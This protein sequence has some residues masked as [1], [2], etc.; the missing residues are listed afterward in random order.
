MQLLFI[1]DQQADWRQALLSLSSET[2]PHSSPPP[3]SPET[4]NLAEALVRLRQSDHPQPRIIC[5]FQDREGIWQAVE[6]HINIR[7]DQVSAHPV[8]IITPVERNGQ[9]ATP[10]QTASHRAQPAIAQT[11]KPPFGVINSEDTATQVG[12]TPA[13][14][15]WQAAE[16]YRQA[17][18]AA[19][20]GL[21]VIDQHNLT[22]L[23]NERMAALLGYCAEE[24]VGKPFLDF[25]DE[26]GKS[27]ALMHLE[28]QR[29]GISEQFDFR[30]LR[31]DGS[32]DYVRVSASPLRDGEGHYAGTL[33]VITDVLQQRRMAAA[34]REWEDILAGIL[35]SAMDAI[36]SIDEDFQVFLFNSAAE[37]MFACNRHEALGQ[38]LTRFL[39]ERFRAEHEAYLRSFADSGRSSETPAKRRAIFGLRSDGEEFPIE[40]SVSKMEVGG[41]KIL[42]IILRDISERV[43]T[44]NALKESEEKFRLLV[45]G[46]QD[47]A[48][49]RLDAEGHIASWNAGAERIMGYKAAEI[50]GKPCTIFYT[51]TDIENFIPE[52]ELAMAKKHGRYEDE[53]WR[54]R[55]D[56]SLFLANFVLT[57]L[58]DDE[59]GLRGFVNVTRDVTQRK[60]AE[61]ALREGESRLR[62]LV[63]SNVIGVMVAT[64]K[65]QVT[66]ANDGFLKMIGYSRDQLDAGEIAG[67]AMT[68]PEYQQ[69]DR[70]A[71]AQLKTLGSC[72]PFEK[73]LI[74]QDRARVSVLIAGT[75]LEGTLDSYI[76]FVLDLTERKQV[77]MLRQRFSHR[78][79]EAQENERRGLA[80]ELHDEIGQ[81][82]T[83]VMINLQA[84]KLPFEEGTQRVKIEDCL[85]LV[86]N[87]LQ[88]VR[89]MS[90]DLR[91]SIL[92]DLGLAAALRWYVK[93]QTQRA[94]IRAR[95]YTNMSEE[96]LPVPIETACFRI[97]QEAITNVLKHAQ[98]TNIF[99]E[100][101]QDAEQVSLTIH[102]NG[103][104]FDVE[105][106]YSQARH[107]GSVGLLGMQERAQFVNGQV[108]VV[109]S[110]RYGTMVRARLPHACPSPTYSHVEV[111]EP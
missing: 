10:D 88:Q 70:E 40:A 111:Y 100:V 105:Q 30:F 63:E 68:P 31:K 101:N 92:D 98:A 42:T 39:P 87:V 85:H 25:L 2:P 43:N 27:L 46:V 7:P 38:P 13:V 49:Y 62:R 54:T 4:Y 6:A 19:N 41:K 35:E 73:E 89:D 26:E 104:S 11:T 90:L 60:Q 86:D 75:M 28:R 99:V 61:E 93:R 44:E 12:A 36:V 67:D 109:S 59:Q 22:S 94:G 72:E 20:D 53:G 50:L 45:D 16:R 48:L 74:R 82:L 15:A 103:K 5:R 66:M 34:I 56:G 107:G 65:G 21:W 64:L 8:L 58:F 108:E 1:E 37:Q 51:Q 29:Q 47:Y 77:E 81:A 106:A 57:P 18:E 91:P 55:Q 33:A 71:I 52:Q 80:R 84:A 3:T 24:M 9:S 79:L 69:V 97:V 96:R 102:D 17:F 32:Y 14:P 95:L 110:E 76:A 83:A 78:L 23:V